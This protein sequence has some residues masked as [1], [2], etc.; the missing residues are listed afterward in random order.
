MKSFPGHT[1][2]DIKY[3]IHRA[4]TG[5]TLISSHLSD[6]KR[7]LNQS[8]NESEVLK[9]ESELKALQP[10]LKEIEKQRERIVNLY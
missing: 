6:V 9:V 2:S 1:K 10:L 3:K 4:K 5:L 8:K 7:K